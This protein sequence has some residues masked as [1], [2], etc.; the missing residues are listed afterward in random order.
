MV[1]GEITHWRNTAHAGARVN[2]RAFNCK[3]DRA[4][5]LQRTHKMLWFALSAYLEPNKKRYKSTTYQS[6]NIIAVIRL[7]F[8][9]ARIAYLGAT[10]FLPPCDL[11]RP[12]ANAMTPT[13]I[14]V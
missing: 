1:D 11:L 13:R 3:L 4:A 8:S 5:A 10:A 6:F 2:D 9:H 14:P 7:A 12:P